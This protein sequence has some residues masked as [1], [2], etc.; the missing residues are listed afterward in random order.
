M[1]TAARPPAP[2]A[3]CLLVPR[4]SVG[5]AKPQVNRSPVET[6]FILLTFLAKRM[7]ETKPER[8]P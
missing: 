1:Q 7:E 5:L 4:F 6:A 3:Q 8:F 2:L